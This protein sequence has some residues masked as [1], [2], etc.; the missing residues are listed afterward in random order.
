MTGHYFFQRCTLF[1]YDIR[2]DFD[3][4]P[5]NAK[6]SYEKMREIKLSVID[7]IGLGALNILLLSHEQH[8]TPTI[9]SVRIV[10]ARCGPFDV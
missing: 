8:T 3:L 2:V 10:R 1:A 7:N 9:E 6:E 5:L 4:H